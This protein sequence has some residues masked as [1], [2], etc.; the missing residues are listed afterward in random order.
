MEGPKERTMANRVTV[1]EVK[2]I[3]ETSMTDGDITAFTTAANLTVT[4]LL[5]DSIVLSSDQL[6]EIERWLTAHL[7]AST[8]ER[9]ALT[10]GAG[11]AEITYTG[12]WGS[13][14]SSTPYGQM[15]MM[16]DTTGGLKSLDKKRA[17]ILAVTS[18]DE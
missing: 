4:D 3:I 18:F 8:R 2:E 5:G 1:A 10:E 7:I 12:E 16:L 9:M 11:G 6:K 15:V 13:G 14:L 17:S